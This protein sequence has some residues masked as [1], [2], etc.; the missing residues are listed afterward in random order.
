[1]AVYFPPIP[2][3]TINAARARFGKGNLY[4]RLGD[5]LN[6]LVEGLDLNKFQVEIG[7]NHASLLALLT[8]FQFIEELTDIQMLEYVKKRTDLKYAL[9]LPIN[10]SNLKTEALCSFRRQL[11]HD[12]EYL[13]VFRMLFKRLYPELKLHHEQ[14][15]VD[16]TDLIKTICESNWRE[17]VVESM[18]S[19]I[20]ALAAVNPVWLRQAAQ[21]HWY[22][23]YNRTA[24]GISTL[25]YY[26][27]RTSFEEIEL[28]VS[29]LLQEIDC[30]GPGE[31]VS[32]REIKALRTAW[33]HPLMVRGE[34]SEQTNVL[35]ETQ[36]DCELCI[37]NKTEPRGDDFQPHK[38]AR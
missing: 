22:G 29:H 3:D 28:D 17:Q 19:A 7:G 20:E 2:V 6:N 9:H 8:I 15:A 5:R 37:S 35:F 26:S 34:A 4:I 10:Y 24:S 27:H 36:N 30:T 21:P 13:E 14:T 11:L 32:L 25:S 23:R 38:I 33:E 1:M 16:I 12:Q 31:I 18:F